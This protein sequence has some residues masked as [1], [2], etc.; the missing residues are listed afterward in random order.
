MYQPQMPEP[1]I[2]LTREDAVALSE[3]LTD[4]G[5]V[6]TIDSEWY[7]WDKDRTPVNNGL[8]L[9]TTHAWRDASG[10]MQLAFVYNYGESEGNIDA[11]R[12]FFTNPDLDKV[13]HNTP[14]DWHVIANHGILANNFE[15]DTM[16]LDW[17]VDENR[18]NKHGLKECAWDYFGLPRTS[19]KENFGTPKIK[20]NGEPYASGELNPIDII[21]V[22][23][24]PGQ[25][26]KLVTYACQDAFD[27]LLIYEGHK[28]T[29]EGIPWDEKTSYWEYYWKYEK[30]LTGI[31]T[32]MERKG[33]Y[34]DVPF[35]TEMDKVLA[36]DMEEL[37]AAIVEW[38]G[39]PVNVKSRDHMAALLYGGGSKD[40]M[41]GK[42]K[43]F[44]IHGNGFPVLR[45]TPTGSPSTAADHL[46]E[47]KRLIEKHD[48]PK[49]KIDGLAK[50][51]EFNSIKTQ[52]GT[53]FEGLA[54]QQRN[55]RVHG[56]INQIGTTSGRF[57]SS[58]PNLQNIT[59]GDKDR[60][61]LRDCFCAPPG[62]CLVVADFSQLEYRLL[63]HFSQDP[64]LITMFI[65]KL[66]MHSLTT[67]NIFPS[68]K[69]EVDERFGSPKMEALDWIAETYKDERKKGKTLNFEII[70]GVGYKKL[71]DQLR[72]SEEAAKDMIN[73]WFSGYPYVK[74]WMNRMLK[75]FRDKGWCRTLSGRYRHANLWKLN[76]DDYSLRGSEERT[77]TNALIQGSAADMCKRAMLH[78]DRSE[79][80]KELRCEVVMQVHDELIF[81]C[82]LGNQEEAARII[83]PLMESPF[84][85][86]LRVPMP[87]TIGIGP[88]WATAK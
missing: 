59:T 43:L 64:T 85:R 39:V 44:T 9:C 48:F 14:V 72:I 87:V 47:L 8:A 66:D 70:Y 12:P 81:E 46:R 49:E 50:I 6:S 58:N 25:W 4:L 22:A 13:G 86:P 67:Y 36:Y 20:K 18:E 40:I 60:Y 80:L 52:K 78:I 88:T 62:Y 69:A 15:A 10:E 73:L 17:L 79:R 37:E 75:Q 56:R 63:A 32:R 54:E 65:N 21:A 3:E 35:L 27:T 34:L 68:I 33:M 51:V 28:K 5:G 42:R 76:S 53:F 41:K 77:L 26:D 31:I 23:N 61:H 24:D 83:R 55:S 74:A 38:A 7:N 84:S 1:R 82:P 71:A 2:I 16:V 45:K 19:F 29:L 11:L 57:S 30:P